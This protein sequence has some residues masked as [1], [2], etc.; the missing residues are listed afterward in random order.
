MAYVVL[1]PNG[2]EYLNKLFVHIRFQILI[3]LLTEDRHTGMHFLCTNQVKTLVYTSCVQIKSRHGYTLLVIQLESRHGYTLL[4]YKSSQDT[5]IHFLC[6]NQVKT[7]V[8]TSCVQIKS[9][10]GYIFIVYKSSQDTGIHFLCTN[11]VKTRVYTSCVQIKSRRGY[12]PLHFLCTNQVKTRVYTSC[13]GLQIKSRD[14][15]TLLVYKSSQNTG[16]HFLCTN[17][18]NQSN[19]F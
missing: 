14:G 4:V 19:S 6:T 3:I 11:Q 18:V 16:I 10:H 15:Y 5:G 7:R 1:S 9:R 2:E 8:Y 13:V 12:R 17:Q